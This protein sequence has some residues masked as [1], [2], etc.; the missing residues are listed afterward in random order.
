MGPC[1]GLALPFTTSLGITAGRAGEGTTLKGYT[2]S[3]ESP[4]LNP[5]VTPTGHLRASQAARAA[6]LSAKHFPSSAISWPEPQL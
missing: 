4:G 1:P 5:R 2:A 6:W 3:R